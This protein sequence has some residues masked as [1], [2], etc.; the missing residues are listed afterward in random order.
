MENFLRL[1]GFEPVRLTS[2]VLMPLR[3][4]FL[5]AFVNRFLAQLPGLRALDMVNILIARPVGPEPRD[6]QAPSVSVVVPARN[7]AGN[8]EAIIE[9]T[10]AM[11]PSDELIFVEG[12]STD[13]TWEAICRAQE[14]YGSTRRIVVAQQEG[15]G[16]G[17]AVR[18]G[19][20]LAH[21]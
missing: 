7:E 16:K 8:I 20:S 19:F 9:R 5:S 13:D 4:P 3:I 10:P 15:T 17:D 18:K 11:G 2:A 6:A 1:G 12:H 14:K 21:E